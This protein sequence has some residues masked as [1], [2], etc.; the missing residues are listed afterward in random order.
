VPPVDFHQRTKV[1]TDRKRISSTE[2]FKTAASASRVVYTAFWDVKEVMLLEI[3][4]T[5]TIII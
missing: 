3:M 4:P 5:G 2:N 1:L